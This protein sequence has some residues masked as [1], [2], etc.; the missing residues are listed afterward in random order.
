VGIP[1]RDGNRSVVIHDLIAIGV[2][3]GIKGFF[4]GKFGIYDWRD[5]DGVGYVFLAEALSHSETWISV[6]DLHTSV[7]PLSLLRLPGYSVI[8]LISK[9]VAGEWW[10]QMIIALQLVVS[11]AASYVLYRTIAALSR[12]WVLGLIGASIFALSYQAYY[13]RLVLTDGL[14]TS[15]AVIVVSYPAALV[16]KQQKLEV[17]EALC[18]GVALGILFLLRDTAVVFALCAAPLFYLVARVGNRKMDCWK[19]LAGIYLPVLV[20]AIAL[21][22]WNRLRAGHFI[23]TTAAQTVAIL[24]LASAQKQ[25]GTPLFDADGIL[26]S[27]ANKHLQVY[28]LAEIVDINQTLHSVYKFDAPYIAK[29]AIKRYFQA[30][31]DHP[32]AMTKYFASNFDK[33]RHVAVSPFVYEWLSSGRDLYVHYC[34]KLSF[35]CFVILPAGWLCVGILF[36][37]FSRPARTRSL[38]IAALWIIVAG[39]AASHAALW[40]EPRYFLSTIGPLFLIAAISIGTILNVGQWIVQLIERAVANLHSGARGKIDEPW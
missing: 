16:Y 2:L 10:M 3:A 18:I 26:D 9:A 27:V 35:W 4:L 25:S 36:G 8:I 40:V 29:I 30:W 22:S 14:Y 11:L 20:L 32:E 23:F 38:L 13:E 17:W 12:V 39:T 24:A 31:R 28:N 6:P 7:L 21:G 34:E 37:A 19:T 15:V 33:F 1:K 5:N